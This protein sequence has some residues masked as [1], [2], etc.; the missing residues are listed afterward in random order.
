METAIVI[1][2]TNHTNH[3]KNFL[4]G[5]ETCSRPRFGTTNTA[6]KTSLKGWKLE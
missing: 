3:L 2:R 4:K 1:V 5:M 6:S